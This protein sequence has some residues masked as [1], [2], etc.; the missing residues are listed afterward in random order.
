MIIVVL[1][2]VEDGSAEKFEN[3]ADVTAVI[4]PVEHLHA[5]TLAWKKE[6][7]GTGKK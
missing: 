7:V 1:H 2:E 5:Q 6:E 4:E 3:D